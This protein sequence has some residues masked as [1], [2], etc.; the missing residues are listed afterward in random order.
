M[1]KPLD[2]EKLAELLKTQ[3][4]LTEWMEDIS[5]DKT[6]IIRAEDINKRE[7]LRVLNEVIGLPYDKPTQF[8][9]IELT[10]GNR[11]FKKFLDQRG[12][13]LCSIRLMPLTNDLPKIRMRGK[14][15]RKSYEW[16]REQDIDP[17]QYRA[18]FMPHT[19]K[20][21][22]GTI[23]IVNKKG[24][25]G[26]IIS[27][28]HHQLTQGFHDDQRPTL[29][30]YDYK[31]WYFS[32][33]NKPAADYLKTLITHINVVDKKQQAVLKEKLDATFTHDYIDGYFE[34]T[35]S[36]V[37]L[38]YVDYAPTLGKMYADIDVQT[39]QSASGAS[40]VQGRTGCGG[41]A[42]GVVQIV[43]P[44]ELHQPFPAGAVLVCAVT[45]PEYV[46]LMMKASAVITD[47]GGILSHAA[48]VARELKKPC[49]V[50]TGSAT[51]ALQ[52]GQ[53]VRVDADKGTVTVITN[54]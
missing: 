28:S 36:E 13:E 6:Q 26:E 35:E 39:Q 18:D 9:A 41:V 49:I 23:F 1:I 17:A 24:I 5:H 53:R 10:E 27:G 42:E 46:P 48:I 2:N 38:M 34:T 21:L 37:G 8:Q 33:D 31:N 11:R 15:I 51:T 45:T 7:R 30:K 40:I 14:T 25:Q 3:K 32:E 19:V 47:Q 16:F 44:K 22:W 12:D 54:G 50:S 43:T 4:S 29:F 52:S 20:N